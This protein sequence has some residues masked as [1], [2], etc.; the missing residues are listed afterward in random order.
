MDHK[1]S[2][3]ISL[4]GQRIKLIYNSHK[5]PGRIYLCWLLKA[6]ENITLS[7]CTHMHYR[8]LLSS[9]HNK[10]NQ[11]TVTTYTYFANPAKKLELGFGRGSKHYL[12]IQYNSRRKQDVDQQVQIRQNKW[13]VNHF[14]CSCVAPK[15]KRE[16]EKSTFTINLLVNSFS[17]HYLHEQSIHFS[18]PSILRQELHLPKHYYLNNLIPRI[19]RKWMTKN[20]K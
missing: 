7:T 13:L 14:S 11:A 4:S 1:V 2:K 9:F 15:R 18:Q 19:K 6:A 3:A 17:R 20:I 8:Y 16:I 10:T 5:F 12:V